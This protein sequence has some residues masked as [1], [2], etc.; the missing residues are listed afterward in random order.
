MLNNN[1]IL[2]IIVIIGLVVGNF[3]Y[4]SFISETYVIPALNGQVDDLSGFKDISIDV[5]DLQKNQIN[6]LR[7][8]GEYPVNP[9][10]T[11]KRNLFAPI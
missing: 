5:S 8:F 1:F 7:I 6:S 10:L 11:G 4:S 3:Y 2:I 9:G